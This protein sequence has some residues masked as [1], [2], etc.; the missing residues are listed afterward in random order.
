MKEALPEKY[1]HVNLSYV[2]YRIQKQLKDGL[3]LASAVEKCKEEVLR[4]FD[5]HTD[6]KTDPPLY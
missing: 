6:Y 2:K 1:V 4:E 3:T 5:Y